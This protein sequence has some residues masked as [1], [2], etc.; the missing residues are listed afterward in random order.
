MNQALVELRS[1]VKMSDTDII[2]HFARLGFGV[3]ISELVFPSE[4][5][6]DFVI[7]R[8]TFWHRG[9]EIERYEAQGILVVSGAQPKLRQPIRDIVVVSLFYARVVMGVLPTAL[10]DQHLPRYARTMG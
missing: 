2:E 1:R 6:E 4:T 7:A 3:T 8:E 9:G 5:V 10:V